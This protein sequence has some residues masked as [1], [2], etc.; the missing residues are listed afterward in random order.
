[1]TPQR[2]D[3]YRAALAIIDDVGASKLHAAERETLIA[4]A[5]DLL[6]SD[7]VAAVAARREEALALL[8]HLVDSGRWLELT[9]RRL[10]DHIG[11]CGPAELLA[12]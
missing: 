4:C 1:M 12:A 9:A 5:E 6:L 3:N 11:A 2:H 8:T 10:G 7:D